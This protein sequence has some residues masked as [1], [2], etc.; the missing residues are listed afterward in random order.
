MWELST[1]IPCLS[2]KHCSQHQA[3]CLIVT[4]KSRKKTKPMGIWDLVVFSSIGLQRDHSFLYRIYSA[5]SWCYPGELFPYFCSAHRLISQ[6][7]LYRFPLWQISDYLLIL[8]LKPSFF[9]ISSYTPTRLFCTVLTFSFFFY[10]SLLFYYFILFSFQTNIFIQLFKVVG[11]IQ[12]TIPHQTHRASS[13]KHNISV[14]LVL[15][16]TTKL[17]LAGDSYQTW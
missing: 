4:A 3:R 8:T 13:R 2:Q 10:L 5:L 1:L 11:E 7:I 9:K 17:H 15:K 6:S 16:V 14:D 12:I